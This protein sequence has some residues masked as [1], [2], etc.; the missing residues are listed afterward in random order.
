MPVILME[1]DYHRWL[2]AAEKEPEDL[3]ALLKPFPAEEMEAIDVSKAVNSP[4]NEGPECIEPEKDSGFG[5]QGSGEED[6]PTLF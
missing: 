4:K 1:E 2:D 5:V 6:E 3:L